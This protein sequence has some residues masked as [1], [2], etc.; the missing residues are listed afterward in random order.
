M[1]RERIPGGP[2]TSRSTAGRVSRR[3]FLA[4]TGAAATTGLAGCL[5]GLGGS[6]AITVGFVLPYSG[7]YSLLGESITN[8]FKLHVD[9]N[10]GKIGGQDVEYVRKDTGADPNTG[11]SITKEFIQK[12][13][14]DFLVGP[15]SSAVAAAMLPEVKRQANT[16]WLNAN[17][18][19][20][21]LVADGCMK[22][23]FRTAFNSWQTSAPL[24]RHVKEHIAD[25]VYLSY[26]DYTF[27][28]QA[29]TF[30]GEAFEEAGG[31][32]VGEVGAPLGTSD[33]SSFLQR[34]DNSGADAVFSFFAGGDAVTYVKQFA[35]F[36]LNEKMTQTGSG[37]LLSADTLPAQGNAALGMY[38]LLHYTPTNEA[39]RN[40]KFVKSYTEAYDTSPNVYA[41][42][43]YDAAQAAGKAVS[44]VGDTN[45]DDLVDALKGA[46]LDS[47]RGAF[48][49]NPATHD[50]IQDLDVRRVVEADDGVTNEV[51]HTFESV[52]GPT[53]GCSL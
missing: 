51:V 44:E 27:G 50:P 13:R 33:Y 38:S 28:Q 10:D 39:A 40:Q 7:T 53:W 25:N 41:C 14:A 26:A 37:F 22:Y 12:E 42:Q 19:N 32:V 36:G 17:A 23:H 8:G 24:A 6:D 29:K 4:G 45:A 49:F 1:V 46:E 11:V 21:E 5:G 9:Q 20:H 2:A 35:E 16:I 30:F 52:E 3:R 31:T 15:V 47:P 48:K 34:I 18:G 43:G